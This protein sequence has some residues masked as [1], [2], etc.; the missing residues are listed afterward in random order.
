MTGESDQISNIASNA[1]A[2]GSKSG[3]AAE[4]EAASSTSSSTL[5]YR[6]IANKAVPLLYE[7]WKASTIMDME[8]IAY[9]NANWL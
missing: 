5:A 2:S 4:S 3:A 8:I 1:T 9:H 6:A 7:Y